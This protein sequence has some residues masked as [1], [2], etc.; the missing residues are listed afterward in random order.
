M[1]KEERLKEEEK[2]FEITEDNSLATLCLGKRIREETE[3]K[4]EPN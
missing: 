3:V 1:S 2:P 4:E